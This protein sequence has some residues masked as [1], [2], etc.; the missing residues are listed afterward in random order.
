[1][2]KYKRCDILFSQLLVLRPEA[3][4]MKYMRNKISAKNTELP[5]KCSVLLFAKFCYK[6]VENE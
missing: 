1:M 5:R 3:N 6:T 2:Q 4:I